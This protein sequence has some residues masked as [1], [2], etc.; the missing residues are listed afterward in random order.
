MARTNFKTVEEYVHTFPKNVW[1]ILEKVR[2]SI[3]KA[4][5][6]AEETISYQMPTYKLNGNLVYYAAWKN[7]IGFYPTADAIKK[8]KNELAEYKSAKGS[9]QF[10][11][12]KPIPLS[13]IEK[14][15]KYRVKTNL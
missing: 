14:I 10:P 4:A 5:P 3:K 15:V 9:V 12:D 6:M 11:Y 8:F 13:L 7:H 2:Q 1:D